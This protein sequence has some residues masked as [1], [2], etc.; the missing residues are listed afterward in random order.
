MSWILFQSRNRG[1]FLFK[2]NRGHELKF[3]AEFQ[4]RNRGSF[5]FKSKNPQAK[6]ERPTQTSTPS[7][8]L[9]RKFQ[10]R[11]RGSFLFKTFE[12]RAAIVGQRNARF[13]CRSPMSW[14]LFQSRNR[15]S[16]LFK[17][18]RG[19]ELK[20]IAEFQSRNRGSFLFK[21]EPSGKTWTSHSFNLVIEVLFFSSNKE[22]WPR[23]NI[24]RG[25][26]LVIEVLFFS[27]KRIR[28]LNLRSHSTRVSIS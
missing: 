27:R 12:K 9:T 2:V 1:S 7:A 15:G 24:N 22:V 5:L 21:E 14:I 16:F 4:S 19:H 11:N 3:I 28:A 17:V 26:N 18:N 10:S 23:S 8:D 20:F 25:F 6:P 13:V